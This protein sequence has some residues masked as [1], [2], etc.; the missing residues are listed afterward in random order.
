MAGFWRSF[1]VVPLIAWGVGAATVVGA[2]RV[3]TPAAGSMNAHFINVGQGASVLLEFSCGAALIDTGGEANGDFNSTPVLTA[4]LDAFFA[5]RTDLHKTLGLVVISHPHIDHT[6]GLPDVFAKYKVESMVD[7]GLETGSGGRQQKAAHQKIHAGGLPYLAVSQRATR[8]PAKLPGRL[9]KR[10]STCGTRPPVWVLCGAAEGRDG[11]ATTSR[12]NQNGSSVVTRLDFGK[13]SFLFPGDLEEGVQD[14]FIKQA[15]PPGA[16]RCPL[17]VDIL[18]VA[19]HGSHN[20]TTPELLEAT[21]PHAAVIA[22]GPFDRPGTFSALGFGHPR[23]VAI[24]RLIDPSHGVTDAR[25][26]SAREEVAHHAAASNSGGP[27]F[28]KVAIPKAVY[29]TGW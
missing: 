9:S 22:M 4:Y 15:C 8:D 20:G 13:A 5:R 27:E 17:D 26:S 10:F 28:T 14:D 12:H 7:D 11:R 3:T 23:D 6:R 16:A 29:G 1:A 19:H 25:Q 18:L 21:T 2:T 24:K